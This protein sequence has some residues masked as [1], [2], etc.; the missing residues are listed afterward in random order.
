MIPPRD[1]ERSTVGMLKPPRKAMSN[2]CTPSVGFA[3]RLPQYPHRSC[4]DKD[5]QRA[6][7]RRRFDGKAHPVPIRTATIDGTVHQ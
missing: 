5:F 1:D 7:T 6:I 3:S 4:R 2:P